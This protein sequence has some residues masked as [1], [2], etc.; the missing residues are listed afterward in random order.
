MAAQAT[1]V[2][3]APEA[4][5]ETIEISA[6]GR[7]FDDLVN[8]VARDASRVIVARDGKPVAALVPIRDLARLQVD[9]KRLAERRRLVE[10]FAEPFK[11][12]PP[13]EIQREVDRAIAAVRA[14]RQTA[15]RKPATVGTDSA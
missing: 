3:N 4:E 5:P 15:G 6:A 1:T 7:Q 14:R 13:D 2:P 12:V 10:E 8:R 9:D 11:D